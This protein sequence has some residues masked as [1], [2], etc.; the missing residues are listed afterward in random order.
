[1]AGNKVLALINGM[2]YQVGEEL[3][4]GGY[5]VLEIDPEKVVL[6]GK[7]RGGRITVPFTE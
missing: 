1:L 7:G 3:E 6:Q 5:V 2:E 4:S